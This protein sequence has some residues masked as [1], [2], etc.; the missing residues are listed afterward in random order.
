MRGRV[1]LTYGVAVAAALTVALAGSALARERCIR[2]SEVTALRVAALQQQLMVAA[3]SCQAVPL[4]NRFVL[5]YRGDLQASDDALKAFFL[6]MNGRSGVSEYHAFKTR[7]ANTSSLNSIGNS[8]GYCRNAFAAF[9]SAP[10]PRARSLA[11]LAAEEAFLLDITYPDCA[12]RRAVARLER[13]EIANAAAAA[14][15]PPQGPALPPD[16]PAH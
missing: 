7:L 8:G 2:A 14:L 6:R 13:R 3:L 10:G 9:E 11:A 4:Y 5:S 15:V 12:D 1:K 16:S